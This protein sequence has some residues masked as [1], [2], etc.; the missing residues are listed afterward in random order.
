MEEAKTVTARC[1]YVHIYSRYAHMYTSTHG[2][3][4]IHTC[5]DVCME[6]CVYAYTDGGGKYRDS[7]NDASRD[8]TSFKHHTPLDDA[9][10]RDDATF[11]DVEEGCADSELR[12]Q[13]CERRVAALE[14]K[15]EHVSE[16]V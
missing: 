16:S 11:E 8:H 10:L 3:T 13:Q 15:F 9:S 6:E 4:Y 2:T 7:H 1:T 5:S 12:L 14:E